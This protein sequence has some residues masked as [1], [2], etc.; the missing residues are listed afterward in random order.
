MTW[1]CRLAKEEDIVENRALCL[2][3]YLLHR[4][5]SADNEAIVR[6]DADTDLQHFPCHA[7]QA[8]V[9]HVFC[10]HVS[11]PSSAR[12]DTAWLRTAQSTQSGFSDV[13]H[14]YVPCISLFTL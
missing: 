2:E 14:P 4:A 9:S 11:V 6:S 5:R 13:G 8:A 3:M 1:P 7:L 10:T 12:H